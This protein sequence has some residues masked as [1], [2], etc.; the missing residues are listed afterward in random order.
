M[1]F[2]SNSIEVRG[3]GK[4]YKLFNSRQAKVLDAL[5]IAQ[6]LPSRLSAWQPFWALRGVDLNI[7]KG[8]RVGIIGRNGAGKSTLLKMICA[9]LAPTEGEIAVN[10]KIQALLEMGTGFHPEFTGRENIRASLAYNGLTPAQIAEREDEIADFAELESFIDQPLKTYSAGMYARLAFST[11]TAVE[12]EILIIDEVL[13][14]GDAYFAAK[15]LERMRRLTHDAGATVLF[16]SH[17]LGSVQ[18][19]CDRAI[20]ID[21]GRVAMDGT[22]LEVSR[23]YYKQVQER[24]NLRRL[25]SSQGVSRGEAQTRSDVHLFRLRVADGLDPRQVNVVQSIKVMRGSHVVHEL[26]V[27][28]PMDDDREHDLYVY[29]AHGYMNW[30]DSIRTADGLHRE[31]RNVGGRFHHA[32]FQMRMLDPPWPEMSLVIE[33]DTAEP[34]FVDAFVAGS[35]HSLAQLVMGKGETVIDLAPVATEL[36]RAAAALAEAEAIAEAATVAVEVAPEPEATAQEAVE[37]LPD[38]S[39]APVETVVP[40]SASVAELAEPV[41]DVPVLVAPAEAEAP[42][43]TEAKSIVTWKDPDPKITKVMFLDHK[44]SPVGGIT[45]GDKLTVRIEYSS[46]KRVL[47]PAFSITF[48][49]PDG[50]HL[51]HANN[52]SGGVAL[53]FI[54]GKGA[55][56]FVFDPFPAGPCELV[57]SCSIFEYLDPPT[58]RT[59]PPFYDQHDRAYE[60]KVWQSIETGIN[61]GL[62]NARYQVR[63]DNPS[64]ATV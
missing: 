27:G 64:K 19:M 35:Y 34:V 55:V 63:H 18:T 16:V 15:C 46:T 14:A 43:E 58:F 17:D 20:W 47:H 54:D 21:R 7:R 53:P 33:A 40:E 28:G 31:F 44:G 52:N 26:D 23:A 32:P 10:G 48:Y 30:S 61:P 11:A 56:E 50:R 57:M 45:F 29:T 2:S 25:A 60:F 6:F 3:V 42:V 38:S 39:D 37:A 41:V 36:A 13:G 8:E 9:N 4:M 59:M 51:V 12:P 49:L 24:E 62:I 22:P 1:T 5:G